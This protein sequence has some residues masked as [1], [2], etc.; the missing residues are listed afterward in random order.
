MCGGPR[1]RGSVS[2]S[3]VTEREAMKWK[4]GVRITESALL[5][6]LSSSE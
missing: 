2:P 3:R 6:T 1:H 4:A 5:R